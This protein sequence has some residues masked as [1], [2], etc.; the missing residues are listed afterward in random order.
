M[1][2]FIK[3]N[4]ILERILFNLLFLESLLCKPFNPY[5]SLMAIFVE[6][7]KKVI[8]I[9]YKSDNSI[10]SLSLIFEFNGLANARGDKNPLSNNLFIYV[11]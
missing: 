6:Y 3:Y 9:E 11:Y 4:K 1:I 8:P 2:N 5:N 7:Y 10:F